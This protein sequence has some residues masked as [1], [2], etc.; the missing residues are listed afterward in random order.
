M[1][2]RRFIA[3]ILARVHCSVSETLGCSS[4]A[5]PP[6]DPAKKPGAATPQL[7]I[8]DQLIAE[9]EARDEAEAAGDV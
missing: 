4:S 6:A 3:S 1:T 8:R 9:Y 7:S 2:C 5:P